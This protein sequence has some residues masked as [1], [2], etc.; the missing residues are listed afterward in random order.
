M[1]SFREW[2]GGGAGAQRGNLCTCP[3]TVW[4]CTSNTSR[5]TDKEAFE[6]SPFLSLTLGKKLY[7]YWQGWQSQKCSGDAQSI[8]SCLSAVVSVYQFSSDTFAVIWCCL[9]EDFRRRSGLF[10]GLSDT[11]KIF[12]EFSLC[13]HLFDFH[14]AGCIIPFHFEPSFWW[15]KAESWSF[16][17]HVFLNIFQFISKPTFHRNL[18][19][20]FQ[21]KI[22]CLEHHLFKI[23]V[24]LSLPE[25][26][27][28]TILF[29][30]I[31]FVCL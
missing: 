17:R 30:M 8:D 23:S 3:E 15:Y 21:E 24:L 11:Q 12:I 5:F 29:W 28:V 1:L 27:D 7:L 14:M 6:T 4:M 16:Q 18:N 26:R 20:C 25:I 13:L 10:H 19:I 31:F 2:R 22:M 9:M